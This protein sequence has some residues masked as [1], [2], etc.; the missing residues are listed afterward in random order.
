MSSVSL[1]P[2]EGTLSDNFRTKVLPQEIATGYIHIGTIAGKLKG[3]IP[4]QT[5]IGWRKL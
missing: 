2:H 1:N 5:P 4:A 3:T